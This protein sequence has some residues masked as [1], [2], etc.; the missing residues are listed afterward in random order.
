MQNLSAEWCVER[1][2]QLGFTIDLFHEAF[3]AAGDEARRCTD[4]DA[5]A[6]RGTTF[7]SRAN[8]FI[9]ERKAE[10][11]W[12]YTTRDSILRTIHPSRSHAITAMSASG[13]VGDLEAT[14][15]SKNPK[16]PKMARIVERN[17][18]FALMSRD[19][20]LYGRELDDIPTWCLLYKREKGRLLAELSLP[21]KMNGKLVDEWLERI[22]LDLPDLGDPG[23]DVALLDGPGDDS[24][25]EVMVELLGG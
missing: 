18:Q 23:V 6:M 5:P 24:G 8:R 1:L 10:E 21:I 14:V 12:E 11:G 9:G 3:D 15:R 7:W 22:P 20:I 2:A 16:G 13:G 4:F 25:P 19:E 17:G